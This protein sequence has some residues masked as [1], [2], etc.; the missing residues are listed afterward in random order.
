MH[1]LNIFGPRATD[2]AGRAHCNG[3]ESYGLWRTIGATTNGFVASS[4]FAFFKGFL[5]F[6]I[7]FS[8][9]DLP[10]WA[11]LAL[12]AKRPPK[13]TF[14]SRAANPSFYWLSR[15]RNLFTSVSSLVIR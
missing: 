4:F 6:F 12:Y 3:I 5:A 14:V 10:G 2:F 1:Y 11:S 9:T 7:L 15:L 8:F 13:S